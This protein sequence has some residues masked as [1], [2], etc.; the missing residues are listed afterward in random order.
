L[1]LH[2][3]G[4]K[5]IDKI[6][7]ACAFGESILRTFLFA[8]QCG[9]ITAHTF[10]LGIHSG[11]GGSHLLQQALPQSALSNELL[12]TG[13]MIGGEEALKLQSRIL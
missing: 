2:F 9:L 7:T 6:C 5:E 10:R 11:M 13:K 12:L 1:D 3:R 8:N 4:K